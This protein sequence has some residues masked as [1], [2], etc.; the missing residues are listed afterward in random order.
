M[1]PASIDDDVAA[2]LTLARGFL[3]HYRAGRRSEWR[4]VDAVRRAA[5]DVNVEAFSRAVALLLRAVRSR[6]HDSSDAF[7]KVASGE[8]EA[9]VFADAI[10]SAE[11]RRIERI[12]RARLVD[13]D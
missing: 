1:H 3:P 8:E 13:S 4:G 6:G 7:A 10:Q 5:R 12:E 9:R 11:L 2:I